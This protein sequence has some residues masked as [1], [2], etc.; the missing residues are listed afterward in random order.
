MLLPV[1]IVPRLNIVQ[2]QVLSVGVIV[3]NEV[4]EL[5]FALVVIAIR[6]YP[7]RRFTHVLVIG[8][9]PL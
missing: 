5:K 8:I 4:M 9:A 2:I 3:K 7:V 1:R 6:I